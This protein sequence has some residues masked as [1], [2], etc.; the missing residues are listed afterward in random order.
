MDDASAD[1]D[2]EP[3]GEP[4]A[5]MDR[6]AIMAALEAAA[7][8]VVAAEAAAESADQAEAAA[9]AAGTA[10]GLV[11]GRGAPTDGFG[12][13]HGAFVEQLIADPA[14]VDDL[15]PE[16]AAAFAARMDAGGFDNESYQDRLASLLPGRGTSVES[17]QLQNTRVVVAGLVS[18]A[19]IASFKR[20]VGR[21]A[22]VQAVTV[23]SGPDGEFI[24]NVTHRADVSFRDLLPTM[25]G[26]AARVTGGGDGV[27]TVTARDPETEG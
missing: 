3:A 24:F 15:D 8:A 5:P 1:G 20:H 19:S 23:A 9:N 10:A 14:V 2:V 22:G 7:E 21:L 4:G 17:A 26:F 13:G 6:G 16:A 18:V 25:P 12:A 11:L 27:V